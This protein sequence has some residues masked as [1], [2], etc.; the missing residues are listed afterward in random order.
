MWPF[1]T[2][3]MNAYNCF[4]RQSTWTPTQRISEALYL[5][6]DICG[7][8]L[9]RQEIDVNL[10]TEMLTFCILVP[11]LVVFSDEEPGLSDQVEYTDS[12]L[13]RLDLLGRYAMTKER[14]HQA[15][16]HTIYYLLQ[17]PKSM[18][19][20]IF[21]DYQSGMYTCN[22]PYIIYFIRYA[23]FY[24]LSEL[25]SLPTTELYF[26]LVLSYPVMICINPRCELKNLSYPLHHR[27][28]E[29]SILLVPFYGIYRWADVF[30]VQ[31]ALDRI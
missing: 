8:S 18:I 11:D 24:F 26:L 21:N 31:T 27:I 15:V 3:H 25:E 4:C 12:W 19:A 22:T 9:S 17:L 10:S 14:Y 16:R 30:H 29:V 13:L 7:S 28:M 5:A 6:L 23:L 20:D 1:L 2:F